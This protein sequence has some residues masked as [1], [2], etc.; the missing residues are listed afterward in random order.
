MAI[1]EALEGMQIDAKSFMDLN[2]K[3]ESLELRQK[4]SIGGR[5]VKSQRN[6]RSHRIFC[7]ENE[8]GKKNMTH[9]NLAMKC[10]TSDNGEKNPR[11]QRNYRNQ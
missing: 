6:Y 8:E 5:S 10:S 1:Q 7:M 9:L 3:C 11:A 4:N 2:E